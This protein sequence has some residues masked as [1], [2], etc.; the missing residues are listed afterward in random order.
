MKKVKIHQTEFKK[1]S[2]LTPLCINH[3]NLTTI[4]NRN[5][6]ALLHSWHSTEIDFKS[7]SKPLSSQSQ[8]VRDFRPLSIRR[9]ITSIPLGVLIL[10]I[11]PWVLFRLMFFGWYSVPRLAVRTCWYCQIGCWKTQDPSALVVRVPC[12]TGF[13]SVP[14][15]D[16]TKELRERSWLQLNMV[17]WGPLLLK[18][19]QNIV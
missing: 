10:L 17:E 5:S 9:R 19:N 1:K 11:H 3:F 7:L 4:S 16:R 2:I 15:L 14:V 13:C 6:K 12:R 18:I 8:C